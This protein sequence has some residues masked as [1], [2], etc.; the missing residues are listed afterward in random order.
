MT[1]NVKDIRKIREETGAGVL[2]A[3]EALQK[4]KG[5]F[6]K[7]KKHLIKK[8]VKKA[9]KKAGRDANDGLVYSYIHTGG[10]VGAM[11]LV[12]CETDFVAKT[13]DFKTLCHNLTMQVCASE[14]KDIKELL[15][16]EYLRE[17]DKKISDLVTEAT[18]KLG[19][20]IEIVKYIKYS[21]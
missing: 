16:S 18:A 2:D 11:I 21:I 15:N 9:E 1:L 20:K 17:P 3:K 7:A 5:D 4:A 13:D 14:F 19:E 8:G 6:E 10:K 12:A